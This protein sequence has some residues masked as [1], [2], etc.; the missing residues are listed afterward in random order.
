[1]A[2]AARARPGRD[3]GRGAGTRGEPRRALGRHARPHRRLQPQLPQ[4][5]PLGRGRRRRHRRR[6]PPSGCALVRN[7]GEAVVGDMGSDAADMLGFNY[8]MGELEAAIAEA[9][10]VTPGRA[11]RAAD[12]AR[13]AAH[14]GSAELEGITPPAVPADTR[15]VYY[16]HAIR[17]DEEVLGVSRDAFAAALHAEGVPVNAGYVDPLYRQPLYR[18]R[19][20]FAFGDP[21]NAGLGRYEHGSARRASGC[22][23]TSCCSTR[24]CTLAWTRATST[25]SSPP[26][27][28]CTPAAESSEAPARSARRRRRGAALVLAA[29]G[30]PRRTPASTARRGRSSPASCRRW[31]RVR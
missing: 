21:R 10:L 27:A 2:L 13:R 8:R 14:E 12:R 25:T 5:D 15:H 7:H 31:R 9:Q 1:M 17:M 19:R 4:D 11:D 20:A 28:R 29:A 24:S 22:R 23:T 6:R 30:P 18:E 26:S 3:R 16:L